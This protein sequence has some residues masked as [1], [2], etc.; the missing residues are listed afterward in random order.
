M[1]VTKEIKMMWRGGGKVAFE[2][3]LPAG[4]RVR[5]RENYPTKSRVEYWLDEIPT[6]LPLPYTSFPIDSFFRH[7]AIHYGIILT[8][9]QVQDV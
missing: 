4:L 1:K 3:Q 9:E 5:E 7:D 6:H 8:E 2:I